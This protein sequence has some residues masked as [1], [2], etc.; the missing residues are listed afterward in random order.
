MINLPKGSIFLVYQCLF[1]LCFFHMLFASFPS[2]DC[3]SVSCPCLCLCMYT[4]G[5]RMHR[6]RAWSPRCKQK[7]RRCKHVDTSQA[8]IFSSFRGLAFPT[9]LC[10]LLNPL[11]FSL[12]SLLDGLY[13][14]YHAVYHSSLSLKY[15]DPYLFSCTYILGYALRM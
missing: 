15:G 12:L 4:N 9:W 7:G 13:W 10:T 5:A 6:A 1:A 3:L 8:P 14:V 2:I 11:P